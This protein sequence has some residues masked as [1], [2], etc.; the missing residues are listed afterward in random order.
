M[1][2]Q[3]EI[4]TCRWSNEDPNPVAVVQKKRDYADAFENVGGAPM[5][6]WYMQGWSEPCMFV[7]MYF[8]LHGAIWAERFPCTRSRTLCVHS[9]GQ[10]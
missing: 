10:P 7:F 9:L 8:V 4:L 3:A 5:Y 6:A 2:V 1:Y